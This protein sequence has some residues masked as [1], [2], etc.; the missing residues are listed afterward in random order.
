MTSTTIYKKTHLKICGI[1]RSVDIRLLDNL[2][3]DY[4]G[5][6]CGIPQGA[7]NLETSVFIRLS[8]IPTQVLKFVIVTFQQSL[9]FF[10][11]LVENS[12][13]SA[14]QLHGFQLPA[15]VKQLKSVLG[16]HIKIF[17]VI[18]VK[19]D[20]CSEETLIKRYLDAGTD[21][22]ILDSMRNQYHIG[23]TAI[24][25]NKNFMDKFML[26]GISPEK[27]I[28][29][30]GI[31]ESN[32][33]SLCQIYHPFGFDIDSAAKYDQ[34]VCKNRVVRIMDQIQHPKN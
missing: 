5:L 6:W 22:I 34:W 7:Y 17:K 21:I 32:I 30:G 20:Y 1:T 25:I 27:I 3:I 26:Q 11:P 8:N 14:I 4:A 19:G 13:I 12:R 29:A 9:K 31:N 33:R 10:A 28:I 15:F 16:S 24:Q 2:G 23:S 18:H